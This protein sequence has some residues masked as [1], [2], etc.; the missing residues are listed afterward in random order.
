MNESQLLKG[1]L[2]GCVLQ[3][4]SYKE[5]YGYEI[6]IDLAKY[7]F[8]EIQEGTLYPVLNRLEKLGYIKCRMGRSPLGPRRKYY[9][10]TE[11]GKIY[12]SEFK[13]AY[14][15]ITRQAAQILR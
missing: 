2:E 8:D 10:I 11:S 3:L 13:R 1:I 9:S 4:I 5:T 7:G 14:L 15:R 12:L 6:I